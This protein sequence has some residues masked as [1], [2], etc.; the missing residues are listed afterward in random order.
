MAAYK[1]R[2]KT[3]TEKKKDIR[4]E[5][6]VKIHEID[7]ILQHISNYNET[8]EDIKDRLQIFHVHPTFQTRF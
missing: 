4:K 1:P 6:E 2:Q 8:E 3:S 7:G 5:E